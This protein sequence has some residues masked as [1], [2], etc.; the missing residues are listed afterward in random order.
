M[1]WSSEKKE[2]EVVSAFRAHVQKYSE[3]FIS[4][5]NVMNK[6]IQNTEEWD[7]LHINLLRKNFLN[8]RNSFKRIEMFSS[9]LFP[10]SELNFNGPI[11]SEIED[12]SEKNPQIEYP[13]GF[14]VIE[15]CL[16]SDNP[17]DCQNE[18][19]REFELMSRNVATL[20]ISF[21]TI[22]MDESR[23][24]EAI[25]Y[26][27]IRVFFHGLVGFDTP[28][29]GNGLEEARIS[30]RAIREVFNSAY[31]SKKE[32]PFIKDH[33]KQLDKNLLFLNKTV[34]LDSMDYLT[35][36]RDYYIPLSKSLA[37]IRS[38]FIVGNYFPPSALNFTQPSVFTK[39]AFNA[40]FYNPRGTNMKFSNEVA[41]LGRTLFFDPLFSEN[42]KRAC[43]S[44][45]KPEFAFTDNV[46]LGA[47]FHGDEK[48][49]RNTPTVLNAAIQRNY[50]YDM[51]ADNLEMQIGHVISNEKEMSGNFDTLV[52]KLNSSPEYVDLFR[53]VFNGTKDTLIS[54]NSIVNAI[55]EYERRLVSFNSK[56][57]RN[58]RGEEQ[59]FTK[60]EKNGFNVFMNKGRCATCHY[61]PLFNNLV[62]PEYTRSE[63][64][65]IGT[66]ATFDTIN[67]KL[68]FDKGRGGVYGTK[69]FMNA[70]KTPTLRNIAFTGPYM[71]NGA[72]EKLEDVIEFYNKGGGKGLGLDIFNQTLPPDPLRLTE[73]E[74]KS[75]LA[76]M[77]TLSDTT[78]LTSTPSRLPVFPENS[79]LNQRKVGGEY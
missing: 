77:K 2:D 41:D 75:L 46:R 62:P 57:D 25:Q 23:F 43:A 66:T 17:R 32:S 37:A 40:F 68:D 3:E 36:L 63:F 71:H 30:I 10:S 45:H 28:E 76:F 8:C 72:F 74:K 9:Y 67:P 44:C 19:K 69:I 50:F 49:A 4:N 14:Q 6:N 54:M 59:T 31:L 20:S 22:N 27:V 70:F 55:A 16:W 21:R 29:C 53:K 73:K 39:S 1:S 12:E 5:L 61:L 64:E 56:F 7:T 47:S 79:E 26:H 38:K 34:S 35:C 11:V 78:H 48:L 58:V 52:W 51:R 60:E 15:A 65:I 18:L 42:N 13:H 33:L 24:I